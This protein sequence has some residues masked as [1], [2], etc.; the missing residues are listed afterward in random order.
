M[1]LRKRE[2]KTGMLKRNQYGGMTLL[3]L[4]QYMR[5]ITVC[6]TSSA[7]LLEVNLVNKHW[8]CTDFAFFSYTG[9]I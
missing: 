8:S 1:Y 2:E 5:R 7:T 9:I 3:I 6:F 4:I